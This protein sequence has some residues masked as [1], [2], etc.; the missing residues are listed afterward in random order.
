ML[1]SIIVGILMTIVT[2]GIHAVGT[3]AWARRLRRLQERIATPP[4][5]DQIAGVL[6][7]YHIRWSQDILG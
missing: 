1:N 5:I 3:T 2:I 7:T 4:V 6:R